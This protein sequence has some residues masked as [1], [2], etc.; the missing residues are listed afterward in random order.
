MGSTTR[1]VRGFLQQHCSGVVRPGIPAPGS[2]KACEALL[3]KDFH[4][5]IVYQPASSFWAFQIYE[6]AIFGSLALLLIGACFWWLRPGQPSPSQAAVAKDL[7]EF[8]LQAAR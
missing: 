4:V 3:S 2:F 1:R 8:P 6:A 7:V 5:A